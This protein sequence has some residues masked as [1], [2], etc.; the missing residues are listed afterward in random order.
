M[1]YLIFLFF[2]SKRVIYYQ[3]PWAKILFH[4]IVRA[5]RKKRIQLRISTISVHSLDNAWMATRLSLHSAHSFCSPFPALLRPL[6]D[7]IKSVRITSRWGVDERVDVP[8]NDY[9]GRYQR[10]LR[11]YWAPFQWE[12]CIHFLDSLLISEQYER[13][14]RDIGFLS[15]RKMSLSRSRFQ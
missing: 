11:E 9:E 2:N 5:Q 12:R 14:I 10:F 15:E 1:I 4:K 13:W 8:W 7:P 6:S 3:F